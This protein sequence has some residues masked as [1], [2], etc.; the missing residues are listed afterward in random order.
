L[1]IPVVLGLPFAFEFIPVLSQS[2]AI[3]IFVVAIAV[4]GL[5]IMVGYTGE[6][7]LAQGAF[8]G[9]GGYTTVNLIGAGFGLFPSVLVGGL[10]AALVSLLAGMPSF[11]V[12]GYYVAISTLVIQFI[13]DWFFASKETEWLTGGSQQVLPVESGLV[14]TAFPV[15][16]GELVHY[17][18][19]FA[20]LLLVVLATLN[21]SRSS[22]GRSMRAVRDNDLAANVLGLRVFRTKLT[23]Y[24]LGGFVVGLAGGLWAFNLGTVQPGHFNFAVTISH[25]TILILGGLGYVWGALLGTGILLPFESML[26]EFAPAVIDALGIGIAVGGVRNMVFGALVIVVLVIEPKGVVSLL[27][28]VKEYLRNW[29]YAY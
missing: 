20:V 8:M 15:R 17:Y 27:G 2:L 1:G 24:F 14:G 23:A 10:L 7:V 18:L 21:L 26:F 6:L 9:I 5:N 11:R 22:I 3:Q 25:Y 29:P 12:K 16:S 19:M 4:L 13:A 28:Q